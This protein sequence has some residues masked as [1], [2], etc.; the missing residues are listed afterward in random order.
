MSHLRHHIYCNAE[1]YSD[2]VI[3]DCFWSARFSVKFYE[4]FKEGKVSFGNTIFKYLDGLLPKC[5]GKSWRGA[6][7]IYSPFNIRNE[8]WVALRIDLAEGT[9]NVYDCNIPFTCDAELHTL[10][11]PIC[12][13]LPAL[14]RESGQFAHLGGVIESAF[15]VDRVRGIPQDSD[16]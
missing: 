12:N 9:V 11:E 3:L 2:I 4:K 13:L 15:K 5:C 16:G 14:F 8:H 6:K 1:K 10:L 7:I